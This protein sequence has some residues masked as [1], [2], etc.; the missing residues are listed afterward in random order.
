MVLSNFSVNSANQTSTREIKN[1]IYPNLNSI[2]MLKYF[3]IL[4]LNYLNKRY[5]RYN[6][7]HSSLLPSPGRLHLAYTTHHFTVLC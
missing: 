5:S 6:N 1:G 3:D 4:A 2:V 7:V